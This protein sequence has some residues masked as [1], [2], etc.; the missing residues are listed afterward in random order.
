MTKSVTVA[1]GLLCMALH[2]RPS[3]AADD[4]HTGWAAS[5]HTVR[6]DERLNLVADFHARSTDE[7]SRARTL[8]G[9]FGVTYAWRPR[10]TLGAGYAFIE[11]LDPR[12]GDLSE[13]RLWQQVVLQRSLDSKPLTHR[14]RLEQ[15]QIER[16]VGDDVHSFRLRYSA[17]LM[18][19]LAPG[20]RRCI[21]AWQ[22]RRPAERVVPPS[23]R[24]R[25][26][27]RQDVRP[28]PGLCRYR[29]E[30]QLQPR[31]GA[32]LRQPVHRGSPARHEQSRH[33][34]RRLY[35]PLSSRRGA[36]P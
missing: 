3:A 23:Q 9:R 32:G 16:A 12:I 13:H 22:L 2:A 18:I 26:P 33:S 28:E 29:T 27:E 15:R 35:P 17:R 7:W 21:L 34:A 20:Q 31:P 14:F 4:I 19:P 8:I 36:D 11:T 6:I 10:T 25:S 1:I 5:F 30:V 24:G